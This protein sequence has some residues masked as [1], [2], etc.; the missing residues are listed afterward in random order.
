MGDG[1]NAFFHAYLKAKHS[2]KTMNLLQKEDGSILHSQQDILQEVREFYASLMG[3][4]DKTLIHV[5]IDAMRR[6]KQL[7]MQ[8]RN[9]LVGKVTENEIEKALQGI[10][11]LKS[12]GADG[13]GAKFFKSCWKFI[14]TDVVAAV[15]EFF[16]LNRIF[17][18]FNKTVVTLIPKN[19]HA[20]GIKDYRPIAS[21]TTFYKII[22]RIISARLGAVFQ[23]VLNHSQAAFIPGQNIHNHIMLAY[24]IIKGYTRQTGAPR[25]MLQIDLQKAYDMVDWGALED[26]LRELGIPPKFIQWIMLTVTTVSY[27]FNVNGVLTKPMQACRG[28]RQ[29]DPLSP[30]L[31]VAIMEYLSRLLI[32]M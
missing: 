31:F 1:N 12:P 8:Q 3:M 22:S 7:S 14:K 25:C 23:E 16:D 30:L 28:V 29:G 21:C 19:D 10:G 2:Q 27:E 15:M 13:Y 6:G 18:P 5:D 24:E 26:I 32:K 20:K 9:F 11:D 4:K 17:I